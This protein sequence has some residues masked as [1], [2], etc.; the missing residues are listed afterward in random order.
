MNIFRLMTRCWKILRHRFSLNNWRRSKRYK[1]IEYVADIP[2]TLDSKT[3]YLE[4]SEGKE[5]FAALI[6]PCGCGDSIELV[7]NGPSPSWTIAFSKEGKITFR[8]SIFRSVK[9]KSHFF[10]RANR[11]E[12]C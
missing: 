8:P 5:R 11:V 10:V 6:C 2:D 4:G 3:I 1:S 9:C 12:W 7:I